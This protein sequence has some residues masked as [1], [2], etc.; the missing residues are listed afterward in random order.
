LVGN[1]TCAEDALF[2]SMTKLEDPL[3]LCNVSNNKTVS[4]K[5]PKAKQFQYQ[6]IILSESDLCPNCDSVLFPLSFR[7]QS[8]GLV[9]PPPNTQ[10]NKRP[11]LEYTQKK[12]DAVD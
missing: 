4:K 8:F 2:V 7:S 1:H 11:L 5:F 3:N 10:P 12:E 9:P 6:K